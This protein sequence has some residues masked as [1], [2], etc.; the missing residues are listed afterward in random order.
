MHDFLS[1]M[2]M[3]SA[4]RVREARAGISQ[5]ELRR[6]IDDLAPAPGL[7]LHE[8]G[9]D[10]FAE[11]KRRSP[12]IGALADGDVVT[13]ALSY[14]GAGAAA[15]SVL[16]E[17]DKFGG[18][19]DDLGRISE[20]LA[21]RA[22]PGVTAGPIPALR[23]D[24]ITDPYQVFEARAW[25]A[26]GVL[27]VLRIVDEARTAELLDAAS[28]AGVFVLLEAF[29]AEELARAAQEAGRARAAGVRALVGLNAR[30]LRSL[31]VEPGRHERLADRLPSGV[32]RVAESGLVGPGDTAR[33]AAAGYEV[34]L[35][36]TAL[37]QSSDPAAVL[38]NMLEAGRAAR[39][40][41]KIGTYRPDG[42]G[43]LRSRWQEV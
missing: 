32:P 9:F 43:A 14:R 24:F 31:A 42:V 17:P 28:E 20:A 13:R 25:G 40:I 11:V 33:V 23:K 12:S 7:R 37:M 36:G 5:S 16:T 1:D 3:S 10:L 22:G 26:G 2:A 29:D 35:V 15:V 4:K 38:A 34:G 6:R 8:E 30:N 27:V 39:T 41:S 19:L 18:S 21:G